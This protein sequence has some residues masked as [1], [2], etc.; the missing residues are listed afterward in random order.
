[1]LVNKDLAEINS[2]WSRLH[3][4]GRTAPPM[5]AKSTE[6]VLEIVGRTPGAIGY[7]DRSKVDARVKQVFELG[8]Q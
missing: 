4:S 2:Y 3:F 6:D 5:E 7:M 8:M 1:M